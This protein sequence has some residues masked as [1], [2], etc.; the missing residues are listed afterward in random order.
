M[1]QMKKNEGAPWRRFDTASSKERE[2]MVNWIECGKTVDEKLVAIRTNKGILI[3]P[4]T[5]Q[6][7]IP[8]KEEFES[9]T[10]EKAILHD[11]RWIPLRDS[12]YHSKEWKQ[13][14]LQWI[15]AH[16]TCERCGCTDGVLQVHHRGSYTL[17]NTVL[18]EGFL[19]P[20]RH[21]ERFETICK[22]CHYKE[23]EAL[24]GNEA[25]IRKH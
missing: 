20:L 4:V 14:R 17:D 6:I 1:V 13:F 7:W 25:K 23:H 2:D 15:Q 8:T 9:L 16:L 11:E 19:E 3:N 18:G 5:R 22:D 10:W 12:F 24:I 21:P